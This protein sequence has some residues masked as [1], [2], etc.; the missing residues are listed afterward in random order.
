MPIL[1]HYT[2]K[3]ALASILSSQELL[4]ST[5]ATSS[6]DVRY[7]DGQYLTDIAPGTMTPAQLSRHLLGHPFGGHRF[8][9]YLAIEVSGLKIVQ[10]RVRVFVIPNQRPLDLRGRITSSGVC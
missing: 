8:T 6:K 7:G 3:A 5:A 10:C 4:A 1:Y 2:T 9:H